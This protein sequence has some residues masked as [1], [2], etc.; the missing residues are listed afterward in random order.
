MDE[1]AS[2][3]AHMEALAAEGGK[4]S[5][6]EAT[7]RL[8]LIDPL[9]MD[10]LGWHPEA[11]E[12][13]S[14]V[15]GMRLDYLVG[16]PAPRLVVE[17]K[18]E[19]QAW[20]LPEGIADRVVDI[21]TLQSDESVDEALRQ[22][23]GYALDRGLPIA[24]IANGRQ[25]VAFIASRLDGIR[26]L[27]G[28]AVVFR[29]LSEMLDDFRTLWDALSP[30]G[31]AQSTLHRLL[32][33]QE[34]GPSPP[35]KLSTQVDNYPGFRRRTAQ[36]TDLKILGQLFLLDIAGQKEV[37]DDF[38]RECYCASGALSQ[39]ALVSREILRNP[40]RAGRSRAPRPRIGDQQEGHQQ[41][42]RVRRS[43]RGAEQSPNSVAG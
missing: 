26:P 36:E 10:C 5:R 27:D 7:T 21:A 14:Q 13:E 8:Q 17:A 30:A 25:L 1:F 19:D 6:N 43:H 24:A 20:T 28:R 4:G 12:T 15:D 35:P 31:V 34:T 22:A 3:R 32:L 39:Y 38:L 23:L 29:S 11:I 2:A 41:E 33:G 37:S 9:L 16:Q 42:A 40:L 18:R